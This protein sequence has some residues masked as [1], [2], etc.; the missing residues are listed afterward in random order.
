MGRCVQDRLELTITFM[1]LMSCDSVC[2]MCGKAWT[3]ADWWLSWPTANT[4]AC[5]CSCQ[6]WTLWT[7]L[8]TVSLFSLYLMN[9][10]FH[11][12]LDAVGN[13]LTV[14]Y[15]SMK[16]DVSFSQ[17]S[18]SRL[19]GE[20]NMFFMCV[21][22]KYCSCLQQCKNYKNQTSFSRVMITNVLPHF[23]YETQ[24]IYTMS[25]KK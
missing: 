21:C 20:Q 14:H 19:L 1:T 17:G 23:F 2:C 5:L 25:H 11:T 15:K 24:C 10:M 6:W 22:K 16:Y 3:V 8:V 9:F 12:T 4:L 13:I 7:Y 18:V